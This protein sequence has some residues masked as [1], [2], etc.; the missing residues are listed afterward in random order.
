M[1]LISFGKIF[2][3]NNIHMPWHMGCIYYM[4]DVMYLY[5]RS[6]KAFPRLPS[7]LKKWTWGNLSMKNHFRSM[8]EGSDN[9]FFSELCSRCEK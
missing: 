3:I 6:Q 7:S 1:N 8:L 9:I 2:Q 4:E 5:G